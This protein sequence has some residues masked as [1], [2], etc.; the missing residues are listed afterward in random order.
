MIFLTEDGKLYSYGFG[1]YG[2]LGIGACLSY[3]PQLVK[4]ISNKRIIQVACGEF[5][6]LALS[7][8]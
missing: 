4:S 1:E 8:I 7:G 3:T 2:V 5:H 6:T